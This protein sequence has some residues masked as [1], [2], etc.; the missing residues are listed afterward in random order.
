MKWCVYD[1]DPVLADMP[2]V[3][4]PFETAEAAEDYANLSHPDDMSGNTE[5][6]PLMEP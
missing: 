6:L 5:I 2:V 3:V 4:G 1:P